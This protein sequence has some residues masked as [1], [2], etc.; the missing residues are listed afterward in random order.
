[1]CATLLEATE[2]EAD[3]HRLLSGPWLGGSGTSVGLIAHHLR[4]TRLAVSEQSLSV[5]CP[6]PVILWTRSLLVVWMP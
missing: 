1:M 6:G 2:A 4:E 3:L 5:P